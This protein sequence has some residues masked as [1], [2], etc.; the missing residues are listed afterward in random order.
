MAGEHQGHHLVA[1]LAVGE[2]LAVLAAGGD[3]Q[4]ED[5]LAAGVGGGAAAADLLVDD[6]VE[7]GARGHQLAPRRA[8]AAQQAEREVDAEEAE[9][10]LEVV[11]RHRALAAVVGVEA[12]QRPHR[13]PHRQVAHPGVDVDDGVGA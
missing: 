13:D 11:R 5:V 7:D 8:R 9:R 12:E 3:E 6:P 10:R 4:A 1:D 2:A